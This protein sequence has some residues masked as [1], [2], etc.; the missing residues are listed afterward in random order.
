[1]PPVYSGSDAALRGTAQERNVIVLSP[2]PQS[3]F[4]NR[5]TETEPRLLRRGHANDLASSVLE[6][7]V[8]TPPLSPAS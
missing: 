1:M 6:N 7:S 4:G 8:A 3:G 5:K 2:P